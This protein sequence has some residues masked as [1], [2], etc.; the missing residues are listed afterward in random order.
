MCVEVCIWRAHRY[1]LLLLFEYVQRIVQCSSLLFN[2]QTGRIFICIVVTENS[3]SSARAR[4]LS[5]FNRKQSAW[6]LLENS[7][8]KSYNFRCLYL[9]YTRTIYI[10][11]AEL[12]VEN[13]FS[14]GV[15]N[16]VWNKKIYNISLILSVI[17]IF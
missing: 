9:R 11:L 15:K 10:V 17:I 12:L 8:G 2:H 1:I 16:C 7:K 14:W 5:N 6:V 13:V 4:S 3:M